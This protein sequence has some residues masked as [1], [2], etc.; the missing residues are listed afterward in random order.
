MTADVG[1][2]AFLAATAPAFTV[3]LAAVWLHERLSGR[4]AIGVGLASLG[5]IIVAMGGDFSALLAGQTLRTLPGNILIFLSSLVWAV[6]IILSKKA[7]RDRPSALVT[8]GTFFFGM[9]FTLPLFFY[10]RA[11]EEI[12][13]SQRRWVVGGVALGCADDRCGVYVE[14]PFIE[15]HLG[16][17]RGG[18]S[19]YGTP[20]GNGGC[21][22]DSGRT[23]NRSDSVRWGGDSVRR[24]FGGNERFGWCFPRL[25]VKEGCPGAR[26]PDLSQLSPS[27]A[28]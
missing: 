26:H 6:F 24:L 12:P 22:S 13:P 16:D 25:P 20:F 5:G 27:Y 19:K 11:W 23:R 1:V 7:V 9:L 18:D 2:A 21:R 15:D 4:Q 10:E 8:S 3:I 17:A 28:V 14:Q